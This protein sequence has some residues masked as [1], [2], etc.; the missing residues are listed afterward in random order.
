MS[1]IL[2]QQRKRFR[3]CW[4]RG[5][6]G[7]HVHRGR[8]RRLHTDW[9]RLL[10][11]FSWRDMVHGAGAEGCDD[12]NTADDD[13]CSAACAVEGGY[14]CSGG[15]SSAADTCVTVVCGDS[16]KMT[17]EACDVHAPSLPPSDWI[18]SAAVPCS[19]A[20]RHVRDQPRILFT[21]SNTLT[22]RLLRLILSA[23]ANTDSD[24]H[25][26]SGKYCCVLI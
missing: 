25:N 20:D 19:H 13:G 26:P 18:F 22:L 11:R 24:T 17:G 1:V 14:Y 21:E 10:T 3:M 15:S 23:V 16:K 6:R 7:R 8:L 5:G 12:G 2:S 4:R 9:S